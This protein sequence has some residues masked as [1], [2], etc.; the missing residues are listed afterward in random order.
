[1]ARRVAIESFLLGVRMAA[2]VQ[3]DP[4]D[5]VEKLVDD[6]QLIRS[7]GYLHRVAINHDGREAWR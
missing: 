6:Q 2:A 5:A 7:L 4:T 1:M 3:V